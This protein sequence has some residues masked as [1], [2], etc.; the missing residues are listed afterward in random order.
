[1]LTTEEN[2]KL[3]R[4]GKG[5]PMGTMMRRYWHPIAL[6]A[7]VPQAD[8]DPIVRK[9][10]GESFVVFRDTSGKV[11]V[12]DEACL[13]RGASM[14]LGRVE[15]GGIRCIYH[16]WKFAT[17]GTLLDTPNHADPR[18]K[19]RLKANAYPVREQSGL[20]WAYIGQRGKEPPFRTFHF[21]QVPATHRT[22]IRVNIPSNYLQNWEGGTDSSHVSILHSNVTRPGW[23]SGSNREVKDGD[24]TDFIKGSWDDM[25][26]K[27]EIENT[28]FGFHYAG[29]R[30]LA[31]GAGV[32][33][34]LVPLFL[35]YG[36]IIPLPGFSSTILEVPVDDHTTST[37]LIDAS[38][39]EPLDEASRLR[40]SGFNERNYVDR[41]FV[42]DVPNHYGQDRKA[43]REK[44]SWSG[45]DGLTQEDATITVSMGS[46]YDRSTEHLVAS[47]AAIVRLRRRLLE[48]VEACERGEEPIGAGFADMTRMRA[49]DRDLEPGAS[50][51]ELAKAHEDFYPA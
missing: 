17:D 42:V 6:S 7:E 36:R 33:A 19:E 47:D 30:R 14:A 39:G 18:V 41:N 16:G 15:D 24:F 1:M 11:G 49:W 40:R 28:G 8:G 29:L 25:S 51:K 34:R 22:V 3:T 13:H 35:P 27:L 4:V 10:L 21:D 31:G 48:A 46:V 44:R 45:L 37:Y 23:L 12:M 5:T 32:N 43:M 50:W 9:L 2:E 38:E 20:V 26:P